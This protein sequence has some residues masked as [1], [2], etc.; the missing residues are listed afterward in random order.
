MAKIEFS[1]TGTIWLID[2]EDDLSEP[3]LSK[4]SSEVVQIVSDFENRYSRFRDG[5]VTLQIGKPGTYLLPDDA[6]ELFGFYF[7]LNEVTEGKFTPLV[8][9]ALVKS[10]YDKDYSFT[11]KGKLEEI[12]S[13]R[14]AIE[15]DFPKLMSKQ[16]VMFDFG[17][18]G[19]GYIIDIVGRYLSEKLNTF[20]VDA[21]G[22]LLLHSGRKK[23][24]RVGLENPN[25]KE[26]VVGVAEICNQSIC[27][28][29]SNRRRWD[30]FHHIFDAKTLHNPEDIL[31]SWVIS[32]TTM[33]A[34]G[35]ATALF[36]TPPEKLL[37]YFDFEYLV[38]NSDFSVRFSQNFPA[39]LF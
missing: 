38:L 2:I 23:V 28:S 11:P 19:K 31:S 34:D 36:F 15:F 13:L 8:G 35:L 22:D 26:Q 33:V 7:R 29:S 18:A 37:E 16:E 21:G 32:D 30:K 4:L 14:T 24:F 9:A 20:S 6:K 25:D 10:G 39:E 1:A 5:S 27:G 3:A 17:A 12:P